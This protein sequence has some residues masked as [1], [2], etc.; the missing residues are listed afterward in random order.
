MMNK[1]IETFTRDLLKELIIK[2]NNNEQL[3]FKRMYSHKNL[4][5]PVEDI[6]SNIPCDKLDWALTQVQNTLA[7]KT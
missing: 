2:C 5:L 7:K 1:T 4:D 6:V 3:I